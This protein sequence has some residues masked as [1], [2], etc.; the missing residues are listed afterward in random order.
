MLFRS[1]FRSQSTFVLPMP[2]KPGKF[3]FM[4]DRWNEKQLEDSRYVWLPFEVG[5]GGTIELKWVDRWQLP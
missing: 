5:S 4:A 2:G 1:T 3:I